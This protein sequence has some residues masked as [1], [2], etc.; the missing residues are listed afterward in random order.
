MDYKKIFERFED[1]N[2]FIKTTK[3]PLVNGSQK[4]ALNRKGNILFNSGDIEGAKRVFLTTG[5]SD[6]LSRIGDAY[7]AQNRY[8]D[9]LTMYRIAPDPNKFEAMLMQVSAV[10]QKLI[11]E[12]GDPSNE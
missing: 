2:T 6:G 3:K 9:A 5:Y 8:M 10:I 12:E 11:H 4:A 1:Q 7:K